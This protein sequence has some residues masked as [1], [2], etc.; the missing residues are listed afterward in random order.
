METR[1]VR[2]DRNASDASIPS[3]TPFVANAPHRTRT[4]NPMINSLISRDT[5]N[6]PHDRDEP[7]TDT[8]TQ[9]ASPASDASQPSGKRNYWWA[10]HV[11]GRVDEILA[12]VAALD[13]TVA[14]QQATHAPRRF[15]QAL[16]LSRRVVLI[17]LDGVKVWQGSWCGR[18]YQPMLVLTGD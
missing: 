12:E 11:G 1:S 4:Y 7:T 15:R 9:S 13:D 6:Q 2:Q 17:D 18:Q 16:D 3:E 5:P 14:A 10:S 8:S